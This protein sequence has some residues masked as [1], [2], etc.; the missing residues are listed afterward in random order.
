MKK[1]VDVAIIGA[2]TAGISA[3]KEASKFTKNIIL[4]DQGPLGTTCA[5]IGCM[6][7]KAFI[8][9]ANYYYDRQY[10]TE[11]GIDHSDHLKV[12]IPAMMRYVRKMR[13]DFTSGIINYIKSL[14]EQ[15]IIGKAEIDE[16]NC[17]KIDKNKITAKK[18]II[19]SG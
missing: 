17:I 16:P 10:L 18:I 13:D 8:Q 2:G 15:F 4:I 12:N 1:S 11:R 7:S 19:A 5:R 6:P 3:F 9:A 14:E